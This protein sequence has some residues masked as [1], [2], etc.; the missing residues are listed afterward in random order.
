MCECIYHL[1]RVVLY[2]PAKVKCCSIC[3]PLQLVY[4]TYAS[5]METS[6]YRQRPIPSLKPGEV[7]RLPPPPA[8][9]TSPSAT[10]LHILK[11]LEHKMQLMQENS[12]RLAAATL[13]QCDLPSESAAELHESLEEHRR[14]G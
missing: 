4:S 1:P 14:S 8:T 13:P 12:D 2:R 11:R 7:A 5:I 6:S 3:N 9:A 10:A